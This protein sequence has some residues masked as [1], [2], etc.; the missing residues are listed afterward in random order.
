MIYNKDSLLEKLKEWGID[1]TLYEH[2]AFFSVGDSENWEKNNGKIEG[3]DCKTLFLKEKKTNNLYLI[4]MNAHKKADLKQLRKNIEVKEWSF[5]KEEDLVKYLGVTPGSVTPF[6]LINDF[7]KEIN[8]ILDK[9][10]INTDKVIFHPLINTA[11]LT[12]K[13]KDFIKFIEKLRYDY[14]VV[15][16]KD[17]S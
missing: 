13:T 16:I 9:D 3:M 5:A 6:G 2:P 11:S 4:P 7:E 14:K 8:L 10:I 15:D 1:Y 17:K 12:V